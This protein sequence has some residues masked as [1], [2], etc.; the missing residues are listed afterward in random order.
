VTI[1][2]SGSFPITVTVVASETKET[3]FGGLVGIATAD[4]NASASATCGPAAAASGLFPIALKDTLFD[5]F[6]GESCAGKDEEDGAEF[7]VVLDR[8][9]GGG[10]KGGGQ[11]NIPCA[12]PDDG[13]PDEQQFNCDLL[14]KDEPDGIVDVFAW[15][16]YYEGDFTSGGDRGWIDF[17][18]V[19][20]ESG[21][22][23]DVCNGSGCGTK[24]IMCRMREGSGALLEPPFCVPGVSGMKLGSLQSSHFDDV[25]GTYASLPIFQN[26]GCGGACADLAKPGKNNCGG[27]GRVPVNFC[28]T[29]FACAKVV[30]FENK[31]ISIC[32]MADPD[33][34]VTRKAIKFQIYCGNQQCQTN[35]GYTDPGQTGNPYNLKAVNLT[36]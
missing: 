2:P 16:T 31:W 7:Y 23:E 12:F 13:T 5:Y 14:P 35:V 4:V 30:G 9:G 1:W 26:V 36:D 20:D 27:G 22:F 29:D 24:E 15:R 21:P 8:K 6:Y 17:S 25:I 10:G 3:F 18:A 11:D 34:C 19:I 33:N 32:G 28:V